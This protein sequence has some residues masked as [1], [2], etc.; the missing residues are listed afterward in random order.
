MHRLVVLWV[1]PGL[2]ILVGL[3]MHVEGIRL[4]LEG[5]LL[6]H[7]V[8]GDILARK[9]A[10]QIVFRAPDLAPPLLC[11]CLWNLVLLLVT[12]RIYGVVVIWVI[13]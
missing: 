10:V 6:V 13:A 7:G 11:V 12:L 1:H 8:E 9:S 4:H 3:P 5:L 2:P